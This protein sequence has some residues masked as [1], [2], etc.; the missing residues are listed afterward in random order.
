MRALITGIAGAA[1]SYLFEYLTEHGNEVDGI[2]RPQCDLLEV[3]KVIA[4]LNHCKPDVVYHLAADADVRASFDQPAEVF[5]N[6]T[7]STINLFEALRTLKQHPTVVLCS[8]SEVY[9]Q[10]NHYPIGEEWPYFPSNPYACSKASQDMLGRMYAKCYG[11]R[12]VITRAFG[13][14]NPRRKDLSL[15]SFARQI[16]EIEQGTRQEL[17]HG[18]LDSVRTF[19]DVRD[20]VKAYSLCPTLPTGTYNIGSEEGISVGQCLEAL[21]DMAYVPIPSR[22]DPQLARPTD[23]TN[24]IPDCWKFKQA[25]GWTPAYTLHESLEWLLDHFRSNRIRVAA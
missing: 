13:Y 1:G 14:I 23:V 16:V 24:Q 11:F 18:N 12:V 22:L 15:S 25:T 6:N 7:E 20:I 8:S 19:C 5:R 9:G 10:P 17:L 21:K 4:K 2:A 3:E